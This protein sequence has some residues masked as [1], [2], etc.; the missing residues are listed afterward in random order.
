MPQAT[1]VLIPSTQEIRERLATVA[2][3]GR[4]LRQLL[5]V[6]SSRDKVSTQRREKMLEVA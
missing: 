4:L 3:E 2:T 1:Q 5:R 6:A